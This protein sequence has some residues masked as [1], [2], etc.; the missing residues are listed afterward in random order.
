MSGV[1]APSRQ[2]LSH[3]S[4]RPP[5]NSARQR[6]PSAK[7]VKTPLVAA[8][9]PPEVISSLINSLSAIS[10]PVEEHFGSLPAINDSPAE[11]E[12]TLAAR[13]SRQSLRPIIRATSRTSV[14]HQPQQHGWGMDYG[15]YKRREDIVDE[16]DSDE[17]AAPPPPVRMAKAPTLAKSKT[18]SKHSSS[19]ILGYGA[20]QTSLGVRQSQQN[21]RGSS[22]AASIGMPSIERL[23]NSSTTS[24]AS[25]TD[26]AQGRG[27][28]RKKSREV[29]SER[30]NGAR[31][32]EGRERQ[33]T[34]LLG[35]AA[36]FLRPVRSRQSLK[37]ENES[38]PRNTS[39]RP[40]MLR[41]DTSRSS[42][43]S[44]TTPVSP[45]SSHSA[46]S[47]G[48]LNGHL[49]PSRRSSLRYS[50]SGSIREDDQKRYSTNLEDMAIDRTLIEEDHSTVKRI[51][52]LQEARERRQK[53]WRKESKRSDRANSNSLPGSKSLRRPSSRQSSHMSIA[54][55]ASLPFDQADGNA[56]LVS[57]P[58]SNTSI[59]RPPSRASNSSM[60][61]STPP[62]ASSRPYDTAWRTPVR[63]ARSGSSVSPL[64]Q[65]IAATNGIPESL[66][67]RNQQMTQGENVDLDVEA[68]L[69]SPRLT[70]TIQHPHTGRVIAF[71]EVGDPGGFAVICCVGMG[72]TRYLT[73]FYDELA[74]TLKLRLITPD[75]PGIG[76]SEP[77]V[78][79]TGMPLNWPDD[80]ELIC[81]HLGIVT[82][83]LL[84]HSAG[85][86]YALA[87]AL[88]MP[89]RTRGRV[90]LLAPWITP[91]Q[92]ATSGLSKDLTPAAN[93]PFSQ[94]ILSILPASFLKAANASFFGAASASI[95]KS[96]KPS[97]QRRSLVLAR[98]KSP[99]SQTSDA[100][101]PS[102]PKND[103]VSC[104]QA[105]NNALTSQG[106]L[107]QRP[108]TAAT[109]SA[110]PQALN[111][112][113]STMTPHEHRAAYDAAL[114]PRIWSLATTNANPAVDLIICL[115]K[116][117]PIGFLYTDITRAVVI[118]H[119][120]RDTRVPVDNVRW[121][122]NRMKRCELRVLEGEGHGLM[123]SASVMAEI[124]GE[125]G[126]EWDEWARLV[127]GKKGRRRGVMPNEYAGRVGEVDHH[128]EE[129][130]DWV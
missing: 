31:P 5:S 111:D 40:E 17:D 67:V 55:E 6:S 21:L 117:A 121:L 15:A 62:R 28:R 87:T 127:K 106:V 59:P 108:S 115:E 56:A 99:A 100:S 24:L 63:A 49:I 83:S 80:V 130:Q 71:S 10:E 77:G 19:S 129:E 107:P 103:S 41:G 43:L 85:A 53:E 27:L 98:A 82:F 74:R 14:Q 89:Q 57:T 23:H 2:P 75:R 47:H 109:T 73:A 52:E 68:F 34:G 8:P 36:K 9:A 128:D 48:A 96:P 72:L 4:L 30:V 79:G 39:P 44:A 42:G 65:S 25:S 32:E 70:Q 123:A 78:N 114:T 101:V 88:R 18:S 38:T 69:D 11:Q 76:E 90:H 104:Y 7:S 84:A 125:I 45:R 29:L 112:A 97:A 116:Y 61:M 110:T 102:P 126:G 51:R 86:L 37:N 22:D 13:A 119:G 3:T 26:T 54:E 95:A 16:Y 12:A 66:T 1:T 120:S 58:Q 46:T 20:S 113:R 118:H 60:I 92:M 50:V 122:A 33:M 91:S 94:K 124:L 93:I 64:K 105:T 35:G 81:D